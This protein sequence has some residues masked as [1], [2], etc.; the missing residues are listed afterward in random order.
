MPHIFPLEKK[1]IGS[2]I[3]RQVLMSIII[4]K[5]PCFSSEE[6]MSTW[7]LVWEEVYIYRSVG[8]LRPQA[9]PLIKLPLT[10][11]LYCFNVTGFFLLLFICSKIAH[12][13]SADGSL[14]SWVIQGVWK[15]RGVFTANIVPTLQ[16]HQSKVRITL[17]A[18]VLSADLHRCTWE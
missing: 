17:S 6:S 8:T 13:S 15:H 1:K 5:S 3:K 16:L 14:R 11:C 12:P 2:I 18:E 10:H 4:D 9:C 7:S